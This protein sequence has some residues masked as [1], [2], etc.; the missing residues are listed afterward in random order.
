MAGKNIKILYHADC[1]DGSLAAYAAYKKFGNLAEYIACSYYNN[2]PDTIEEGDSVYVLDLY[3][4]KKLLLEWYDRAESIV[5][6]DHHLTAKNSVGN[7]D[8]CI[9]DTNECGATMTWKYLFPDQKI[10]K[11]FEYIRDRD[12]WL[13]EMPSSKEV[14]AYIDYMSG[15]FDAMFDTWSILENEVE[16]ELSYIIDTGKMLLHQ[17]Q[18]YTHRI[19]KNH[20]I[21]DMDGYD[22][23][24]VCSP[25]FQSELGNELLLMYPR[26]SFAVVYIPYRGKLRCSLRSTDE[27]V[28]VAKIAEKYGGGGHRNSSGCS[29]V[30]FD[31][32]VL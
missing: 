22:V 25:I 4:P 7:L 16:Q 13:W 10:P 24:A 18:N 30:P 15:D 12:L 32:S 5:L 20:I 23:P 27:R 14:H 19:L 11:L 21:M 9:I 31:W 6:L 26:A 17:K 3:F 8:F 28:D 29:F 1:K 2:S